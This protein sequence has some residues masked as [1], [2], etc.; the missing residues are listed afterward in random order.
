M[1]KEK[2]YNLK[3]SAYN[4]KFFWRYLSSFF[5]ERVVESTSSEI[6]PCLEV[7]YVY[8]KYTLNTDKAN[9]SYGSLHNVLTKAFRFLKIGDR[10]IENVLVLGFGAGSAVSILLEDY[11]MDCKITAVEKDPVVIRLANKYFNIDRFTGLELVC[12]DAYEYVQHSKNTFDLILVDVFIDIEVPAC[13][14]EEIFLKALKSRMSENSVLLFNHVCH[15][16]ESTQAT[17][18]LARIMDVVIG[19]TKIMQI[20]GNMMLIYY[21]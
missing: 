12:D 7:W 5:L 8:G 20:G 10:S 4:L 11:K 17:K 2:I 15:T 19:E 14:E 6:N 21:N 3:P 18:D 9:Y 16:K 1:K 13:F